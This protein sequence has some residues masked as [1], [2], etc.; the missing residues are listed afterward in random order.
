MRGVL[1]ASCPTARRSPRTLL[2]PRPPGCL[3]R[4]LAAALPDG[5]LHTHHRFLG[6][7]EGPEGGVVAE[8]ETPEGV[9]QVAAQLLVGCD[10]GQ[11]AVREAMLADGPPTFLGMSIWRAA[12]PK[13]PSWT[14][15]YA[16]FGGAGQNM[17]TTDLGG[18]QMVW[19]ASAAVLVTPQWPVH[20]L[21]ISLF[22]QC[23]CHRFCCCCCCCILLTVRHPLRMLHPAGLC[24]LAQGA[25]RGD[26]RRAQGLRLG[27]QRG[28]RQRGQPRRRRAGVA[29]GA[30]A[31]LPRG[32]CWLPAARAG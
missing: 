22:A 9:R 16:S 10:G 3:Q 25:P 14:E 31:A 30:A 11:S 21:C 7:T 23:S 17:I 28:C 2:L 29:G 8:F 32:V 20:S 18:G 19:Q 4:E 24:A 6:Y 5:V 26:W 12:R 15:S 13:P 27:R 1:C